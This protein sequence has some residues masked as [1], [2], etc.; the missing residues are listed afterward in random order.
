MYQKSATD[1]ALVFNVFIKCQQREATSTWRLQEGG[2]FSERFLHLFDPFTLAGA[3]LLVLDQLRGERLVRQ[4]AEHWQVDQQVAYRLQVGHPQNAEEVDGH[5]PVG[6]GLAVEARTARLWVRS[7][8]TQLLL[9]LQ[10]FYDEIVRNHWY[11]R[12]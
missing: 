4:R 6:S 3:Q 12:Y 7:C 5:R 2:D 9:Y 1:P 8:V 11:K 10:P